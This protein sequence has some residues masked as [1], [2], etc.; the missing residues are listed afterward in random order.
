MLLSIRQVEVENEETGETA[1]AWQLANADGKG[2]GDVV[3]AVA[4]TGYNSI[5]RSKAHPALRT[6][7]TREEAVAV[8]ESLGR[9]LAERHG[10]AF[11]IV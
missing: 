6:Y 7:D 2:F 8:A 10:G 4:M 5:P 1:M 9:E 11:E 3:R